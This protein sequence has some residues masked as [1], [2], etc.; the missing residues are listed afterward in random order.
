MLTNDRVAV[1]EPDSAVDRCDTMWL[2]VP[3]RK[4]LLNETIQCVV[5][6]LS[7]TKLN[8][9]FMRLAIEEALINAME[10]GNKFDHSK[11]V[12]LKVERRNKSCRITVRDQGEGFDC[13]M[14]QDPLPEEH[15]DKRRGRG[16][17]LMRKV[18]DEVIYS[19]NG[20]EVSLVKNL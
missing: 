9:W 13:N 6:Y 16:I 2:E 4:E 1:L 8:M 15:F 3:P 5:S 14:V 17:F 11:T 18:M 20:S 7:E 19:R 12:Y 10:H